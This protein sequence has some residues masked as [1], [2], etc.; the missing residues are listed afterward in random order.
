MSIKQTKP[1]QVWKYTSGHGNYSQTWLLLEKLDEEGYPLPEFGVGEMWNVYHLEDG[2][3][4]ENCA[5][6]PTAKAWQLLGDVK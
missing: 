5:M 1:G 4:Y 6:Y 2:C 3:I